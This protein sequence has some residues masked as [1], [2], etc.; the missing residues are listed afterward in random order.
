M[1]N[2]EFKDALRQLFEENGGLSGPNLET[3]SQIL[4]T[5]DE[6]FTVGRIRGLLRG[7]PPSASERRAI[8]LSMEPKSDQWLS[9][10]WLLE[11]RE[12]RRLAQFAFKQRRSHVLAKS[13][14]ENVRVESRFRNENHTHQELVEIHKRFQEYN[15]LQVEI[16]VFELAS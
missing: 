3:I 11:D 7:L 15:R 14:V 8:S 6:S 5:H 1:E 13:F 12:S 16:E 4:R 10:N 9:D 2:P